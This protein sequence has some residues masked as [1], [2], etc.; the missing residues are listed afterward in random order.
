[1]QVKSYQVTL[2]ARNTS[3]GKPEKKQMF[4]V[5]V[6]CKRRFADSVVAAVDSLAKRIY[7]QSYK[8]PPVKPR[9]RRKDPQ[10]LVVGLVDSHFGKLCWSPEVGSNYDLKIAA[11]LYAR[12]IRSAV[13]HCKS[14]NI[15]KAILPLG[16]DFLHVDNRKLETE[17][18]TPQDFD[19]RFQKM[20]EVAELALMQAVAALREVCPVE[21][22]HIPGNHDRTTSLLLARCVHWAFRDDSRVSVDTSPCNVKYRQFGNCLLGFAH[23]DGPSQ[24]ALMQM[25]PV[26]RADDW[27]ASPACREILTG[28]LHQEKKVERVGTHEQAGIKFRILPSL[29]GTDYWHFTKGYSLSQKVTQNLIYSHEHGFSA[30]FS[31]SAEQL[32]GKSRSVVA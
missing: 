1:V 6:V 24:K 32:L 23:G 13:Q 19:G 8:L 27:A 31:E 9:K 22:L 5:S 14:R 4:A 16:N 26:E 3:S 12:A 29:C 28:H 30:M 10:T 20:L 7:R 17:A 11:E 18:G 25:L 21:C 15:V 2:G